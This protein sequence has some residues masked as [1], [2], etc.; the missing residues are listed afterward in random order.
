M[1]DKAILLPIIIPLL[2]GIAVFALPKRFRVITHA[3]A[4]FAALL[5]L[6]VAISLFKSNL[7]FSWPWAGWGMEFS[8]KLYHFSAFIILAVS[9]FGFLVA[10]YS[11]AFMRR[12]P[13]LGQFY[14]YLLLNISF[15]SGAALADNLVLM[16]FFWEGLLLALFGMISIGSKGAFKTA[17]KAFIIVGIT[18]LCMLLGVALTGHL[19]GTL[20]ISGISLTT[21]GLGGL[22]F[23]LL[24]TGAISKAGA[25]P[26]HSWIPDAAVDAPLPFMALVPAALE[27]LLGVY[28]LA[29][30]SLD[31]F[32][33]RAGSWV[34]ILLMIIGSITIILA[35]MMAL[36]QKDYK[37]LLSYHAISQVG[38]MILGIATALPVGIIGGLFHMINHALYKSCLF[39]T[40]GAVERQAGSTN[41]EELGGIGIRMPATFAC[42]IVAAI[43]ISGVPP[44]NG[45]FSKEL[46]YDGALQ[47]GAAFYLAA[48]LGSFFTAVSF[49]KL[50]QSAFLGKLSEKNRNIKE[51][52]VFMLAPMFIIASFCVLFGLFNH[53]PI[54]IL[55]QPIL[56]PGL[57]QGHEFSGFPQDAKLVIITLTVLCA[58]VLFHLFAFRT[59]GSA[60]KTT[61]YVHQAPVLSGIYDKA[62][63][64]F[65][66]PYVAGLKL[67]DKISGVA[68]CWDRVIDRVYD[69][70]AVKAAFSLTDRI[71]RLHTGNYSTYLAWSLIGLVI[72]MAVL[73]R[74]L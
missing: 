29:R 23:M 41:L 7:V 48:V 68:F 13:S 28:F 26:F 66:D 22:A 3:W 2:A 62:E 65:L 20:S 61:D 9:G 73:M 64:G 55:I 31:M 49:L 14:A 72:V 21:D 18:D 11:S 47:R 51:A 35:V 5:N 10:L 46:I 16:L 34:S 12:K 39:L 32:K 1:T 17:T 74:S 56:D 33:L 30:I 6:F 24:M 19:A 69:S 8:L 71:R 70:L 25:M 43:S 59:K 53:L 40:G 54:K 44:L 4:L 57:I 52:P 67:T 38:Y 58:A 63:K 36:I 60:L 45:F 27:K 50:G 15:T 37:K 42:F